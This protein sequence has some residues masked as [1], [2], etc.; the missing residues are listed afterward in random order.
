MFFLKRHIS[1]MFQVILCSSQ[2][3]EH[4]SKNWISMMIKQTPTVFYSILYEKQV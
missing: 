4:S 3:K 1:V 2:S